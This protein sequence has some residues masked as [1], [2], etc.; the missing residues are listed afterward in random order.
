M[1]LFLRK[2]KNC[3]LNS[4]FFLYFITLDPY[5]EDGSGSTIPNECESTSTSLLTNKCILLFKMTENVIK[6]IFP[7]RSKGTWW[8]KSFTGLARKVKPRK[9]HTGFC[10]FNHQQKLKAKV[11]LEKNAVFASKKAYINIFSSEATLSLWNIWDLLFSLKKITLHFAF[12]TCNF[13]KKY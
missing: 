10:G 8:V 9:T 12:D 13:F 5:S 6:A 2:R 4:W 11:H 7:W 3:W 1:F